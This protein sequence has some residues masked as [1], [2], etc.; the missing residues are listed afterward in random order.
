L[1]VAP[2]LKISKNPMPFDF[3]KYLNSALI[4]GSVPIQKPFIYQCLKKLEMQK[5]T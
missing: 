2:F 5:R 4:A 3:E 1:N